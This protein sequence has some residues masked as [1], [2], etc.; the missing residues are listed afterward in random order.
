MTI[1]SE[2]L[3]LDGKMIKLIVPYQHWVYGV[4]E[5]DEENE[6]ARVALCEKY[7]G[8]K[9]NLDAAGCCC[10]IDFDINNIERVIE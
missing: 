3:N 9:L 4:V 1:T 10:S 5:I 7:I 8:E 6:E 2:M